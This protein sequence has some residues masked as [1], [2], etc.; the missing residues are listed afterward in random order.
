MAA[1]SYDAEQGGG[2]VVAAAWRRAPLPLTRLG[3]ALA[4]RY[5]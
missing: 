3:A 1:V 5:L 4:Y 2:G